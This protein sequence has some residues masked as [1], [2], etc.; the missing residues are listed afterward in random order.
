MIFYL[1]P[2]L[3][4]KCLWLADSID[5][6]QC[7]RICKAFDRLINESLLLQFK[8]MLTKHGY[9]NAIVTSKASTI[10]RLEGLRRHV[11]AWADPRI[12]MNEATVISPKWEGSTYELQGGLFIAGHPGEHNTRLTR[13][14]TFLE[15]PWRNRDASINEGGVVHEIA[16]LGIDARDFQVDPSQ[17]LLVLVGAITEASVDD[18]VWAFRIHF[19]TIDTNTQHP[20]AQKPF[21]DMEISS[22]AVSMDDISV[23]FIIQIMD[24][25]VAVVA[26][27]YY[28]HPWIITPSK[29]EIVN[30]QTGQAY[31]SIEVMGADSLVFLDEMT[32]LLP[33]RA[34]MP[35]TDLSLDVYKFHRSPLARDDPATEHRGA[36]C[37]GTFQFPDIP[38]RVTAMTRSRARCEPALS[39]RRTPAKRTSILTSPEEMFRPSQSSRIITL[40]FGTRRHAGGQV[41]AQ[42]YTVIISAEGIRRL[43]VDLKATDSDDTPV[44]PVPWCEWGPY[45]TRWF[46]EGTQT[47]WICYSF[48]SRF[49]RRKAGQSQGRLEL[50][51]FNPGP[52]HGDSNLGVDE[53]G[54]DYGVKI[55]KEPSVMR[56]PE[57]AGTFDSSLPCRHTTTKGGTKARVSA[58]MIDQERVIVVAEDRQDLSNSNFHVLNI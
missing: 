51:D 21:I 37:I 41:H 56:S 11:E 53:T 4:I 47:H 1:P 6:V 40:S 5:V 24:D 30:W 19:R 48:G 46:N 13:A 8:L 2:E 38:N 50:F 58:V 33:R 7:R 3:S 26:L 25:V 12:D 34:G 36:V 32:F 22:G 45:T 14:L 57:W 44:I 28:G 17:N 27:Q 49:I 20:L 39:Y 42:E 9:D 16:D 55:L 23:G 10:E 54:S 31:T 15:L 52:I 35:P 29:V 18:N 43:A